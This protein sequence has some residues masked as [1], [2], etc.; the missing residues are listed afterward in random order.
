MGVR[1]TSL[2][3]TVYALDDYRADITEV[4]RL[5]DRHVKFTCARCGKRM[6]APPEVAGVGIQCLNCGLPVTIPL[7]IDRLPVSP[8]P[9]RRYQRYPKPDA[10]PTDTQRIDLA[11]AEALPPGA[12][13]DSAVL[14]SFDAFAPL[15]GIEEWHAEPIPVGGADARITPP[16]S[17]AAEPGQEPSVHFQDFE[18]VDRLGGGGMGSV[19]RV[20]R[21]GHDYALK[22]LDPSL[23]QDVTYLRR[24]E[25]EAAVISKIEHPNLCRIYESG[26]HERRPYILMEFCNGPSLRG[27]VKKYGAMS[28]P[29]STSVVAGVARGLR[30]AAR[31][32]VIHR[33]I[34]PDNILL[35]R[36]GDRVTVKVVDFGL[37]K[38]VG[39]QKLPTAHFDLNPE[40]WLDVV[41][42][43]ARQIKR[44]LKGR[45]RDLP[46]RRRVEKIL[47]QV[48]ATFAR[49]NPIKVDPEAV[50]DL[51]YLNN[52]PDR[53][54]SLGLTR[55]GECFGT[56]K[57]MGPE[58]WLDVP[59]DHRADIFALGVTWY[60]LV[61]GRYPF[62]GRTVRDTMDAILH[63][64]P[65]SLSHR[66]SV[67]STG[68]ESMIYTMINKLPDQRYPTYDRLIDDCKRL[69]LGLDPVV[70]FFGE[71]LG[72]YGGAPEPGQEPDFV[73]DVMRQFIENVGIQMPEQ[74]ILDRR[75]A[76]TSVALRRSSLNLSPPALSGSTSSVDVDTPPPPPSPLEA[77][78]AS[79][80]SMSGLI[81]LP[82]PP[83]PLPPAP[84]RAPDAAPL[85]PP[86]KVRQSLRRGG[87]DQ[88]PRPKPPD[89]NADT[90]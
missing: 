33:D 71:V 1:L 14:R 53:Q 50:K 22:L 72:L 52:I 88:V 82:P 56:P 63:D 84:H 44:M 18:V 19:Y 10:Q 5:P 77:A 38:Q 7:D 51:A 83:P 86:S 79:A 8:T 30:A 13:R 68:A 9:S 87:T 24:F 62:E 35:Q 90:P 85:D 39:R 36:D 21:R 75:P 60:W 34:K 31:N 58:L 25:Q 32:G 16:D 17:P 59:C 67:V 65:I 73:T 61:S 81:D 4:F 42:E 23:S 43:F 37:I 27:Y 3:D 55:T 66:L 70:D 41:S 40:D 64:P 12:L 29:M 49:R 46:W 47:A 54:S 28:W 89:D 6:I 57:F 45:D 2:S 20:R 74:R 69:I 78:P 76:D 48:R 11:D 80:D 15:L 26:V